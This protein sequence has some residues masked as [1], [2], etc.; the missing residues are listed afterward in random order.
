MKTRIIIPVIV[1]EELVLKR[2]NF[3]LDFFSYNMTKTDPRIG[4]GSKF[5]NYY[6][7]NIDTGHVIELNLNLNAFAKQVKLLKPW[8][9]MDDNVPDGHD[10][11]G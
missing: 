8:E 2:L 4:V 3:W 1:S 5:A 10:F 9:V 7:L 11:G 6:V